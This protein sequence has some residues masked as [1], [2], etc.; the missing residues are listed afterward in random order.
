[1][2]LNPSFLS[3]SWAIL[4]RQEASPRI[5]DACTPSMTCNPALYI[6]PDSLTLRR[7]LFKIL[8]LFLLGLCPRLD[9]GTLPV[10][11]VSVRSP[12]VFF[13]TPQQYGAFCP[14]TTSSLPSPNL[15]KSEG[16]GLPLTPSPKVRTDQTLLIFFVVFASGKVVLRYP[17][18]PPPAAFP[19]PELLSI[20]RVFLSVFFRTLAH[21]PEFPCLL[22][23]ALHWMASATPFPP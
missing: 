4:P 14:R 1:M 21:H 9:R 16:V 7:P 17:L 3:P 22:F 13:F 8:F 23:N 5:S 2:I 15:I 10:P 20:Q 18:R 19:Y 11:P 6:P 12:S